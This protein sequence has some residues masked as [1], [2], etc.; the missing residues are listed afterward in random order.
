MNIEEFKTWEEGD[1]V[2]V[3][4]SLP[5][6]NTPRIPRMYLE[7][8]H[9][10]DLLKEKNIEVGPCITGGKVK[11]WREHTRKGTWVF[12][13]KMLDKPTKGVILKEEKEVKPKPA[14]KKRAKA[15]TKKKK[16]STG[17]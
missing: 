17:E 11:N 12:E 1:K 10:V 6:E 9:V 15:S 13:K 16:V 3:Y 5:L 8:P 2:F 7:P 4:I 14:N